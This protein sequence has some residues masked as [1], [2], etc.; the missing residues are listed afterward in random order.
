MTYSHLLCG[1]YFCIIICLL[2][3]GGWVPEVDPYLKGGGVMT[4]PTTWFVSHTTDCKALYLA[5]RGS[6]WVTSTTSVDHFS[7]PKV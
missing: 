5:P 3:E 2:T 6:S 4:P 1:K 7:T